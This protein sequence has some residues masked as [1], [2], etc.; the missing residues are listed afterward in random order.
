MYQGNNQTALTSQKMLLDALN[1]L[2]A[3]KNFKDISVSEICS[4]SGISRQTFYSLFGTK[5][6][7]LLYQLEQSPFAQHD[8]DKENPTMTLMDSCQEYGNFVVSNYDQL[9]MLI[10]ND[11]MTVLN[12]QFFRAMSTCKQSFVNVSA[13]EQEYAAQFMSSGLCSLSRRYIDT[14]EK[15][16]QKELTELAYKLMSGSIYRR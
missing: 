3:E 9:K 11:L 16:D 4:R 1:D 2:L 14:H 7:I 15:P 13:E 5:E 12:D 10:D 8:H 6:K